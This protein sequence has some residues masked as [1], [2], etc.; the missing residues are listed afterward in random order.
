MKK[1]LWNSEKDL[2]LKRTRGVLFEELL[3]SR[4][5]G[6]EKHVTRSNQKLML[7]EYKKYVWV[8]PYVEGDDHYFFK[9]AFPS[10]KY[11]TKYLRGA[12]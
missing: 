11:T 2:E 10:R 8:V 1:I 3:N 9:T 6:I 7:F 12:K 5:I 4:F